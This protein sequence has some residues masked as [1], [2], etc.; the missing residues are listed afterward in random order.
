M[1]TPGTVEN[2]LS[3]DDLEE[4]EELSPELTRVYRGAAA[5]CNFLGLDRPDIQFAA[6]E[7]SRGMAKPNTSDMIRLKRLAR[8]LIKHPR[9]VFFFPHREPPKSIQV[10][11]DSD[12]AGCIRTRKSTQGGVVLRGGGCVKSWASTQAIIS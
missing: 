6:R 8:Y 12:W 10:Y 5:R 4:P 9:A 7:V 2:K 1:E 11:S 3:R